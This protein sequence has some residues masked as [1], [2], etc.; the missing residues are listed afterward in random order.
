ASDGRASAN[1]DLF[2]RQEIGLGKLNQAAGYEVP[3]WGEGMQALD[4]EAAVHIAR[5]GAGPRAV[6]VAESRPVK[7]PIGIARI[8]A[9][10]T[11]V[12]VGTERPGAVLV[13][14]DDR[15]TE[16]ELENVGLGAEHL[17]LLGDRVP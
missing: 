16:H 11:E 5:L 15:A 12:E 10:R 2:T 3:A 17:D 7:R 6:R 13:A 14:A 4:G 8:D 9:A 1:R